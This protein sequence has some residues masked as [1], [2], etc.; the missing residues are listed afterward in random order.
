MGR[1]TVV[2]MSE[3]GRRVQENGGGGTDHGHGG[4]LYLMSTHIARRPVIA[5][6]PGLNPNFLENGDL[7]ITT[8]YRDVL[9]E[10]LLH[11]TPNTDLS[12]VFPEHTSRPVGAI[13]P[14]E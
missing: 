4:A 8:D 6:W 13:L 7:Q 3:F 12:V 9:S 5:E 2:A 14:D 11:R 10:L 1:V